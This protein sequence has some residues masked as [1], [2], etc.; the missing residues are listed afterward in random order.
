M[1]QTPDDTPDSLVDLEEV[2]DQDAENVT[3]ERTSRSL[4][5]PGRE[6]DPASFL[7]M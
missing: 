6:G 5:E 3:P 4:P 2:E 1:T 7:N